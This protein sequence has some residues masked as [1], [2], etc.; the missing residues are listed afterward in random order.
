MPTPAGVSGSAPRMRTSAQA[1]NASTT[2]TSESGD[3]GDAETDDEEHEDREM[4][5]ERRDRDHVPAAPE[6]PERLRP[7]A[8]ER[9]SSPLDRPLSHDDAEHGFASA[10]REVADALRP[11][12]ARE[13]EREPGDGD[14][15]DG[16]ADERRRPQRRMILVRER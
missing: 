11:L 8:H 3:A 12:R 4:P 1:A 5:G 10:R 7:E 16:D 6:Q 15:E 2:V 14:D 13:D 9:L